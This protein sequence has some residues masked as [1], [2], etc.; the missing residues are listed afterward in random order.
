MEIEYIQDFP[1]VFHFGKPETAELISAIYEM[2]PKTSFRV[3]FENKIKA[4]NMRSYL[5]KKY[6][7]ML[8]TRLVP[9]S[10]CLDCEWYLY[11]RKNIE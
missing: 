10:D 5:T 6:P 3:K 4:G 7:H 2:K 9:E 1:E 8:S 11:V